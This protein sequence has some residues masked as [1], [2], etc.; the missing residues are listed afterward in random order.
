M[1]KVSIIQSAITQRDW[2][3]SGWS[4]ANASAGRLSAETAAT[5]TASARRL[6]AG[7]APPVGSPSA[8][9]WAASRLEPERPSRRGRACPG[10]GP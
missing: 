5:V 1:K 3:V 10:R 4:C 7:R 6:I 9:G 8:P 2:L